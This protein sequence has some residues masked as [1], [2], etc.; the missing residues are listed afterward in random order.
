MVLEVKIVIFPDLFWNISAFQP[1]YDADIQNILLYKNL[2]HT[3][4]HIS[5][6]SW[7]IRKKYFL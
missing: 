2:N 1:T 4:Y 6:N 5:L 3:Y 7:N